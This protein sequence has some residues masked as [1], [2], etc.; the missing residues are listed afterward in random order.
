MSDRTDLNGP[1]ST[2]LPSGSHPNL[3][4]AFNWLKCTHISHP[5]LDPP[6][7]IASRVSEWFSDPSTLTKMRA[8]ALAAGRPAATLDVAKDL[9]ATALASGGT[10]AA[11]R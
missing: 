5:N 10:W 1:N 7:V 11:S 3:S 8:A 2:K 4:S 6:Q 9:G